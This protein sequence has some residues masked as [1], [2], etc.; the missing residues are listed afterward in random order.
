LATILSAGFLSPAYGNQL[1]EEKAKLAT[2]QASF[3]S[4]NGPYQNAVRSLPRFIDLVARLDP[5]KDAPQIAIYNQQIAAFNTAI[6]TLGPQVE[7]A[8]A[9][10]EAQTIVVNKL[11]TE[12]NFGKNCPATWGVTPQE[13]AVNNDK[14]LF[15]FAQ[16]IGIQELKFPAITLIGVSV[17]TS[18]TMITSDLIILLSSQWVCKF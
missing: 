12:L 1:I 5:A 3:D 16:K 8:R 9:A 14:G 10:L 13:T 4:I 15:N 7:P 6:T 11:D 17:E 2:L 18:L